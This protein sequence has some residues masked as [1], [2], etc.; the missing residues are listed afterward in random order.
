MPYIFVFI[1]TCTHCRN[2]TQL[3]KATLRLVQIVEKQAGFIGGLLHPSH[4]INTEYLLFLI[5]VEMRL[6]RLQ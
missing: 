6:S 4:P 1:L 5:A 3:A 2:T